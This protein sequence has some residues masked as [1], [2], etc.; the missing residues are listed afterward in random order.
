MKHTELVRK[1]MSMTIIFIDTTRSL[2]L[3]KHEVISNQCFLVFST[4]SAVSLRISLTMRMGGEI[5]HNSLPTIPPALVSTCQ[6]LYVGFLMWAIIH[7]S[8]RAETWTP[9]LGGL[10][11]NSLKWKPSL[12]PTNLPFFLL[13]QLAKSSEVKKCTFCYL[14]LTEAE[15]SS[16][17]QSLWND[18]VSGMSDFSHLI[19]FYPRLPSWSTGPWNWDITFPTFLAFSPI[20]APLFIKVLSATGVR[21]QLGS[22]FSGAHHRPPPPFSGVGSL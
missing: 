22:E 1:N 16:Q 6:I 15:C 11:Q 18:C 12:S 10:N 3:W 20:C 9:F 13:N 8:P 21:P 19:C 14:W 2:F 17:W 4:C 7:Q 5:S